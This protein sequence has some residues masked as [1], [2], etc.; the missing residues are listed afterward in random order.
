M[1]LSIFE[2]KTEHPFRFKLLKKWIQIGL[3]IRRLKNTIAHELHVEIIIRLLEAIENDKNLSTKEVLEIP[4]NIG[5]E[6]GGQLKELLS[7]N[8]ENAKSIAKIMDFLHHSMDI[9][10]KTTLG[11][12]NKIAISLWSKCPVYNQIKQ[13]KTQIQYCDFQH[14]LYSG[15]L[16]TINPK[17]KAR[18][19]TRSEACNHCESKTWIE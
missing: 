4:Y 3:P 9:K 6:I 8:T 2:Y 16:F 14:E 5:R 10:G 7:I 11:L 15:I 18:Q 19:I 12:S 13:S 1:K 17:V